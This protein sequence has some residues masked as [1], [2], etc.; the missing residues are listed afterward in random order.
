MSSDI[1]LSPE[2]VETLAIA[3]M[4]A[5]ESLSSTR[6]SVSAAVE[7]AWWAGGA[8]DAFRTSWVGVLAPNVSRSSA[9]L[10]AQSGALRR[11]RDEQI[12]ASATDGSGIGAIVATTS[13]V[14]PPTTSAAKPTAKP[15]ATPAAKPAAKPA[16]TTHH[17]AAK[18]IKASEPPEGTTYTE[19]QIP[20]WPGQ[21]VT[22]MQFFIDDNKVCLAPIEATCGFGDNREFAN[23]AELGDYNLSSRVRIVLNHETGVAQ[24]LA[25]PTHNLDGTDEPAL[26][27]LLIE[28]AKRSMP[29]KNYTSVRT[30]GSSDTSFSFDYLFYNSKTTPAN[31]G[32]GPGISGFHTITRGT[33]GEV[34]FG[35]SLAKYPSVEIIRDHG[36]GN[37]GFNS[38][39]IY[40][41]EQNSGSP[42]SLFLPSTPYT[43]KG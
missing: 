14:A 8:A 2:Q 3:F 39:L 27:I 37:G 13:P 18:D 25:Y 43:A 24:V 41:R 36:D 40:T 6:S 23:G 11:H 30:L 4:R 9:I 17:T 20:K 5:S 42:K 38:E 16:V 26:P 7:R 28:N 10:V 34:N 1:G 15:T 29:P 21:G 35:G 33:N 19:F 31:A 22:R 32:F 12:R